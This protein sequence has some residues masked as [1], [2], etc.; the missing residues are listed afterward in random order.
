MKIKNTL[1]CRQGLLHRFYK[2]ALASV[3]FILLI[4]ARTDAAPP[5]SY[6]TLETAVIQP[7]T[8][9]QGLWTG[10][11]FDDQKS[12]RIYEQ[13]GL[14][15]TTYSHRFPWIQ[16][17]GSFQ[18][19][20]SLGF[21]AYAA[22]VMNGENVADRAEVALSNYWDLNA[23]HFGIRQYVRF[24]FRIEGQYSSSPSN[25]MLMHQ[26]WQF[27]TAGYPPPF[28]IYVRPNTSPLIILDFTVTDDNRYNNNNPY[29]VFSLTAD[30]ER[31]YDV[32]IQLQPSWN[33]DTVAGQLAVW[34][35]KDPTVDPYDAV[36]YSDW[37]YKPESEGGVV[38]MG[39]NF[40]VRVGVYRRK[41]PFGFQV[42]FD[43]IKVGP[44]AASVN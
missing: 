23:L 38:G 39:S 37:G 42:F 15:E 24:A 33:G 19:S 13:K 5:Y 16:T 4:V 9:P 18:G 14:N 32:T 36:W 10:D 34:I 11:L 43:E 41:Q 40:D 25:W 44:T 3:F 31:W 28:A 2:P 21:D 1:V 7:H 26:V 22:T 17:G 12:F 20:N 6:L 30:T 29:V 8:P 35:D 27:N